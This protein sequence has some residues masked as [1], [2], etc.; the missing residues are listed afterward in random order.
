MNVNV[1]SKQDYQ[2]LEDKLG[3]KVEYSQF[4]LFGGKVKLWLIRADQQLWGAD[5]DVVECLNRGQD[6]YEL[7]ANKLERYK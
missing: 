4:F 1:I 3:P 2:K 6:A 7:L 5:T